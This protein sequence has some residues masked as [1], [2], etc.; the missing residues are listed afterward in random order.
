M[1]DG[2]ERPIVFASR[3]LK[4]AERNY[5]QIGK[6]ALALVRRVKIFHLYLLDRHFTLLTDHEPLTSILNPKKGMPAMTVARLQRY[7][8]FLA[9][10]NYSIEYKN[11]TQHGTAD[12]LSRL[13]LKKAYSKGV[14]DAADIFEVSE[15]KVLPVNAVM[16][17]QA[18]QRDPILLSSNTR[19]KGGH[20]SVKKNLNHSKEGRLN[21]PYRIVVLCGALE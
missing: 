10:F 13:P 17:R 4:E 15:L 2:S 14:A 9:G 7:A 20:Q 3:T 11:T 16:I 12:G 5:S 18:T 19:S 8:L 6:E 1:E 21:L